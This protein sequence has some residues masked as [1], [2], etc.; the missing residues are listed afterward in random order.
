MAES[1]A[2]PASPSGR[3]DRRYAIASAAIH[4]FAERGLDATTVDDIAAAAGVAPRTF[5]RHFATKEQAAFPDHAERI[6]EIRQWLVARRSA[7]S[8]LA[9][10][11]EVA[12]ASASE[13]FEDP[14]LYR[15]RIRLVRTNIALRDHERIVDQEYEAALVEYFEPQLAGDPAAALKA[16]LIGAALLTAVNH[17]LDLW[18]FDES[19]DGAAALADALALVARTYSPVL[20]A[21]ASDADGELVLRM[22]ATAENRA[23][24]QALG[25][26]LL[27][28]GSG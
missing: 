5:F 7:A 8:P 16:R 23:A 3:R 28:G 4:L 17:V 12:S 18:A 26:A 1:A 14:D 25:Q 27:S 2:T 10:A 15:P 24:M 13:Y 6:E 21:G 22:P 9:A 20:A 19:V 11:I